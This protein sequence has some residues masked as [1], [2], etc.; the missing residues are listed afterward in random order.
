MAF[1]CTSAFAASGDE[2]YDR[3]FSRGLAQFNEGNYTG[4]Y[5]AFKVAAFGL[6]DDVKRFETAEVYMTV[7]A[8]KLHHESDARASALRVLAAERIDHRYASLPLS[9]AVR[10]DFEAAVR[11]LLPADQ[12]A[13][14]QT[15]TASRPQ[16]QPQPTQPVRPQPAPRTEVTIP[17]P[18]IV[19]PPQPP[20]PTPVPTP[21]IETPAPQPR[22]VQPQPQPQPL[23]V[24]PQPQPVRP[25]P[26]VAAPTLADADRAVNS[27]DLATARTLY[28]ALLDAPQVTHA[29]ALRVAEGLYRSR[30]FAGA[31]RAFERAGAIGAGEEQYH[32]YYAVALY[33]NGR[34]HE[35]KREMQAALPFIEVT[36]DVERYR[37]KING[38]IE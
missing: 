23:V 15:G 11:T 7:S 25:Q 33:E 27:G 13:F 32:Y 26:Q 28:R 12:S 35:A 37:V 38:A 34:Y 4:A 19:P 36:P 31:I 8:M 5:A 18:V 24:V 9:D 14:L 21:R 3:L 1:V 16:P 22:V 30:D 6:L 2:F 10:K 17:A 29:T 20:K